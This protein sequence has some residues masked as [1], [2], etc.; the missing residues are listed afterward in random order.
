MSTYLSPR[1]AAEVL[2]VHTGAIRKMIKSGRLRVV[3]VGPGTVRIPVE[4]IRE[5][6]SPE[7][8]K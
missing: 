8:R 3:K 2:G 7:E 1:E 5:L 4:A 6:E